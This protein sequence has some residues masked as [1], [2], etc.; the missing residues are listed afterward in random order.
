MFSKN[1]LIA[2]FLLALLFAVSAFSQENL[3][4]ISPDEF[5][6]ELQPLKQFKDASGRPTTLLS[7]SQVYA[8]FTG[9][10]EA[11]KVK[12]CIASYQQTAGIDYVMLVGDVDKFPVRW[13]W[14]GLQQ[15]EYWGVSD[16]YYA[17]LYKH[18]TTTFDDW[19]N[20]NNGLYAEIEFT[21]HGTINNDTIDFLPDVSVGRIPASFGA[22]VTA[23]VNKVIN[24]EL[25]TQPSDTWFKTAALYTGCWDK[26]CNSQKDEIGS[27]LTNQG[28]LSLTKRYCDF[29]TT[30]NQPPPCAPHCIITD[31]NSGVGFVNYCGHGDADGWSCLNFHSTHICSLNN[32]SKLPVGF[33]AACLTGMFARMARFHP[34]RDVNGQ[35]HCGTDNGEVLNPGSYPHSSL[36]KPACLQV[37]DTTCSGSYYKFDRECFAENF[38]FDFPPGSEGAIAYLGARTESR[39]WIEKLDKYFFQAYDAGGQRILGDMW[40]YMM[41]QYYNLYDIGN[42]HTWSYDSTHWDEGHK[43]DEPQKLIL[44]GDPSLVVG[45][46]FTNVRSGNVWDLSGGP[47]YSYF[48]YRIVGDVTVP[49]GQ[50]LTAYPGASLLFVDGKK[51]TALDSNPSNGFVINGTSGAPVYFLSVVPPNPGAQYVVHGIKVKGQV[52]LR[53]GG[54]IKL[55]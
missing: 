11:E 14:W 41:E 12:K 43:L 3:L 10:D 52:K 13:R 29:D 50:V 26:D 30:P 16:L 27:F 31:L 18:G 9:A 15:Q 47:W 22:E 5:L 46:A 20:N 54:Q 38:I 37:G 33:G 2:T 7:L 48:R 36:P 8:G 42:S 45:G 39:P 44:F 40:K 1:T 23:Y 4:I 32:S 53:N 51:I 19:D 35:K 21:P 55:Y 6:D 25:K 49:A 34:Y 17:D 28:F 24:Y